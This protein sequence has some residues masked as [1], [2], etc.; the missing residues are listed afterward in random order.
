MISNTYKVDTGVV[1]EYMETDQ[2]MELALV[3]G[4]IDYVEQVFTQDGMSVQEYCGLLIED[5]SKPDDPDL[6]Y[7]EITNNHRLNQLEAAK[8]FLSLYRWCKENW[9][10]ITGDREPWWREPYRQT[11]LFDV[12]FPDTPTYYPEEEAE[13]NK[14]FEEILVR[15]IK[16]R[17]WLW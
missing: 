16:I 12:M 13:W 17:K 4:L 6:W 3:K 9:D 2:Q 7:S 8:E 10:V 1:K 14:Q 11:V 5:L 15:I